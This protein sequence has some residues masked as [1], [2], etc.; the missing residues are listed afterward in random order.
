VLGRFFRHDEV[1]GPRA[2]AARGGGSSLS[3]N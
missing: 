3:L 1:L 2:S